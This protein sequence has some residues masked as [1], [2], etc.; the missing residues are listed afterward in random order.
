ML[1]MSGCRGD[2]GDEAG[3]LALDE[4]YFR[5]R[6]QPVLT[7]SCAAFA[8]HGSSER[9]F[10]VFAR[11]RLRLGGDESER[12]AFLRDSERAFNF[13][14]AAAMVDVEVP[15]RSLLL[16]KPLEPS[17][18]GYYHVGADLF[19]GADVF[20]SADDP[21]YRVLREWVLGATDDAACLEP[22]SDR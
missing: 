7:K 3:Q 4:P 20:A 5:C 12:A 17:A 19:G 22:G 2:L 15:E 16:L 13:A 1:L 11:G 14:S 18:G 10:T 8:C 9:F 21:D 6:V